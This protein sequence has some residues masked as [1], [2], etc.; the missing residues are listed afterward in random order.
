MVSNN[1]IK[2]VVVGSLIGAGLGILYAPKSGKET[3][4]QIGNSARDVLEKAKAQYEEAA[5]K[6]EALTTHNRAIFADKKDRLKKALD[7]GLEAYH[8]ENAKQQCECRTGL[9]GDDALL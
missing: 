3:R 1:L 4:E 2:G 9:Y 8:Q 5:Q 6:L 7:A